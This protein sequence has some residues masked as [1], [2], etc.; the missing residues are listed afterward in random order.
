VYR[1]TLVCGI[2]VR[3]KE[4]DDI[5]SVTRYTILKQRFDIG[6]CNDKNS[7]IGLNI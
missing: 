4:M 3:Q 1:G 2:V 6:V 7:P 5:F